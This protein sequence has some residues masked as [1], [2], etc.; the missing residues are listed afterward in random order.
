MALQMQIRGRVQGVGYRAAMVDKALELGITG[1]VRNRRD[2]GVEAL[3]CG[4]T[5]ALDAIVRWAHVG[6]PLARVES[7][8]TTP[9]EARFD[10]FEWKPTA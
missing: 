9:V 7:V 1:W 5:E 2:G 3:A 8:V 6:P 4:S 10:T